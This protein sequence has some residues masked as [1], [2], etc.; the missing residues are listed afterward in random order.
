MP[1]RDQ[2]PG[3]RLELLLHASEILG[4]SFDFS[5]T[6]ASLATILVPR[7][8]DGYAVDLV[9]DTGSI[10][11]IA[12]VHVDPAMAP[13]CEGLMKLG[14]VNPKAP[15]GIQKLI[16]EGVSRLT[17]EVTDEGLRAGARDEQ[18]LA[19]LRALEPRSMIIV[20]MKAR[21]RAIGLLWLYYSKKSSRSYSPADLSFVEEIAARAALAI[22]NARLWRES[23][24]AIEARDEFLS[25]ASHELRTPLTAMLLRVQGELRKLQRDAGYAPARAEVEVLL[26]ALNQQAGHLGQLVSEMLDVSGMTTEAVRL[27]P[28]NMDLGEVVSQTALALTEDARKKGCDLTVDA[29]SGVT[30]RWDRV[31]VVQIVTALLSNAIKYGAGGPISVTMHSS[32]EHAQIDVRDQ[33]IGIEREHMG[34]IFERFERKV[35]P[36]NYGGFGLGLWRARQ[37]VEASGGTI[38]VSSDPGRGA[39]FRVDLPRGVPL[40]AEATRAADAAS[41]ASGK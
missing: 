6:L 20:P 35:S 40:R 13:V 29:P 33:G 36:R 5:A 27:T 34:R 1:R 41:G 25:I 4:Q 7:L 15:L 16:A 17:E 30:G 10:R 39:T 31:R 24:E 11:R 22:E 38:T 19:L 12:A 9:D 18:H 37:I 21:G 26:R 14:A 28:E 8:A 3:A 32:A 2:L 23:Q